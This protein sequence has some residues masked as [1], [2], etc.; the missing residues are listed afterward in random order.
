MFSYPGSFLRATVPVGLCSEGGFRCEFENAIDVEDHHELTVET[1][2]ASG[3]VGRARIE[4]DG[5]FFA[6]VVSQPQYFADLVDQK[7][8]GFAAQ[9]DA[10]RHR[11]LAVVVLRQA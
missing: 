11:R 6:A 7:T 5:V 2:N 4:V 9:V 10:D 1:M 3:E 8:I